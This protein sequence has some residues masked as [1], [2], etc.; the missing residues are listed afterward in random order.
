[1]ANFSP[2]QRPGLP[3]SIL[4]DANAES[5]RDPPIEPFQGLNGVVTRGCPG[6]KISERLRRY[7]LSV[8]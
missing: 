5:V 6:L 7:V 8:F 3:T 2:G 1:L 4:N